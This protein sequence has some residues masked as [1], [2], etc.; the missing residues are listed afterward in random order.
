MN[1]TLKRTLLS[2]LVLPFALGAQLANAGPIMNWDYVVDSSFESFGATGG[3]GSVV[4]AADKQSISWGTTVDQS[5]IE[6]ADA[7]GSD[8]VTGGDYVNGGKFTHNNNVIWQ[9]DAAL[10]SFDLKTMLTL[11]PTSPAGPTF[12]LPSVTFNGFFKETR[13]NEG[14]CVDAATGPACDDIFTVANVSDLGSTIETD[15]FGEDFLQFSQTFNIGDGYNYTL[16]L[17]LAGLT[18]LDNDA[19]S[20]AG[21]NAGCV[22]LLTEE[23]KSSSFDT[24]FRITAAEVPEP[25]TIAL[26]GLGLAGLGLSRR[27]AAAKS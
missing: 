17:K 16:F 22:G 12:D 4:R 21:A 27:K 2:S 11:T 18:F 25:G 23:N 26:L 24:V 14:S 15:E 8:L 19:C 3:D 5:S 1:V 6:I 9:A 13:N 20:A 7:A 10:T